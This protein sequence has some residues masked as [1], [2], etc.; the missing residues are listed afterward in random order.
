MKNIFTL[1]LVQKSKL[2]E[3]RAEFKEGLKAND[4]PRIRAYFK[5]KELEADG[6]DD[7]EPEKD[8]T[9]NKPGFYHE[10]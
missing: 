3:R 5:D 4:L 2:Q 7:G 10:S 8:R 1:N 6:K 9:A